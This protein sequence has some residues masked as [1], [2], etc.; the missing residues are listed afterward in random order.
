M[1]WFCKDT[2]DWRRVAILNAAH[3]HSRAR[4]AAAVRKR[5]V[6]PMIIRAIK[7]DTFGD[8]RDFSSVNERDGVG[9]TA[10][11]WAVRYKK[12]RIVWRLLDNGADVTLLDNQGLSAVYYAAY[13]RPFYRY[14][15]RMIW[16]ATTST[17]RNEFRKKTKQR[18]GIGVTIGL[19]SEIYN[20]NDSF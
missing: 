7:E 13:V 17:F 11:M 19:I 2:R 15:F 12:Q 3:S 4:R 6:V 20:K 1:G 16:G 14:M 8:V 5:M 9:R 10:L 18:E